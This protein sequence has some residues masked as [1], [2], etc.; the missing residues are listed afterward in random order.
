MNYKWTQT[1]IG[2]V[3][4]LG[5]QLERV[6]KGAH[7]GSIKTRHRYAEAAGRFIRHIGE[8]YGLQRIQN[9][10]D[11]H[12][13]SYAQMLRD[14]GRADKYIK[15][16]LSA[17]RYIHS[18]IPQPKFKLTDGHKSN[19]KIGLGSTPDGR[20]DRAWSQNEIQEAKILANKMG[21][22]D[23]SRAIDLVHSTGMRLDEA[24]TL[25]RNEAE[26]ALRTGILHLTN[27]KG[28]RPR[29]VP[30]T[31]AAAEAIRAVVEKVGRGDYLITPF[32][33]SKGKIHKYKAALENFLVDHRDKF[34]DNNRNSNAHNIAP[35]E[36]AALTWHGLRHTYARNEIDRL[37]S[38]GVS[39]NRAFSIVSEQLGHNREEVTLIYTA[40]R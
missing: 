4:N 21:R 6:L 18:Q 36:R 12:L 29:D 35:G 34:Q 19:K 13:E 2:K 30:L 3:D 10:Q 25:R 14:N 32:E 23:V 31:P 39:K 28:G 17:I 16:E 20:C 8:K 11:K 5:A 24:C 22:S 40:G 38:E 33:Y 9:I 15:T 7:R 1:G 27:T 26:N 37:I